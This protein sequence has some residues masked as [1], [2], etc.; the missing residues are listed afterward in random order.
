[1]LRIEASGWPLSSFTSIMMQFSGPLPWPGQPVCPAGI[2][3]RSAI[4][5]LLE[6][7]QLEQVA[8]LGSM[9]GLH[10]RVRTV[11]VTMPFFS[12]CS[13]QDD[14]GKPALR[15]TWGPDRCEPA[16]WDQWHCQGLLVI[17]YGQ[18]N[19][20]S[21]ADCSGFSLC[22]SACGLAH[23]CPEGGARKAPWSSHKRSTMQFP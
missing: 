17:C 15:S 14:K 11:R 8:S 7:D 12:F 10:I 5:V 22:I 20:Q 18:P 3:E 1:M 6:V 13:R 21:L 16:W 2:P 4:P 23:A 19:V 9:L